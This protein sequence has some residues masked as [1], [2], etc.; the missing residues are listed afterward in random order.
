M[1][2]IKITI[3]FIS[4]L[5]ISCSHME[6]TYKPTGHN[7]VSP[8]LV[9]ERSCE[10]LDFILTTFDAEQIARY[11]NEDGSIMHAEIKIDDSVIMLSAASDGFQTNTGY[12]HVFV[13]DAGHVFENAL[14][15]G[16]EAVQ[17]PVIEEGDTDMRGM[18]TDPFG[19]LWAIATH[20]ANP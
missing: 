18:F 13:C 6:K 12:L 16:A 20:H 15:N 17:H 14:R 5:S 11:D 7:A 9:S 8:Y 19:N 4:L 1:Q 10:L 3:L 2:Y